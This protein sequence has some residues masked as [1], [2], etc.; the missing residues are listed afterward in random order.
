M[1]APF[2]VANR[3]V[4]AAAETSPEEDDSTSSVTGNIKGRLSSE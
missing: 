4:H 1:T 2:K 3:K